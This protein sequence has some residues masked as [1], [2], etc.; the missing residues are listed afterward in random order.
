M[1]GISPI[2]D[3]NLTL[4]GYISP[5]Q[6][7]LCRR[8]AE[9]LGRPLVNVEQR[10]EARAEMSI[11]D[12]RARFGETRLKTLENEVME[13]T[14]LYR[15]AVINISGQTLMHG[16]HFRRLLETGPVICLTANLDA[17]LQRLH[18]ALGARYHNPHERALA[19]GHLKREWA[20]R[21]LEGIHK[22][23]T[24]YL[25]E[26]EII[27]STIALWQRAAIRQF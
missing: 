19:L 26:E 15:G 23:D 7:A 27:E 20:V 3:R 21:Q 1:I 12:I 8:I 6:L 16:E 14:Y 10:M 4:T 17:V 24:T 13:E 22:L 18:A 25:S 9:R 11:P 2:A 5:N